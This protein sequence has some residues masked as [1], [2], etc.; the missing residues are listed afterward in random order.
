MARIFQRTSGERRRAREDFNQLG[1]FTDGLAG[2]ATATAEVGHDGTDA[3]R[4][5]I[6]NHWRENGPQ[7]VR[8]LEKQNRLD[9]AV[10]EA[11]ERSGD[12]LYELVSV[13]KMDYQAAWE[14]AMREWALS[15]GGSPRPSPKTATRSR[16]RRHRGTSG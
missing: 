5:E 10:F 4:G 9:Q 11:Q 13:K 3:A 1:L 2:T 12:L 8:D 14:L 7:M 15:P 6:L 16:N